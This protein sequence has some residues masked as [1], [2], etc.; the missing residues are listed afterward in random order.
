MLS[1]HVVEAVLG[2]PATSA[3]TERTFSSY[4]CAHSVSTDEDL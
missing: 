1:R 4:E 2:M 3:E